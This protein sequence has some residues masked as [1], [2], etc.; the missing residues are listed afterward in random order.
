MAPLSGRTYLAAYY[1]WDEVGGQEVKEQMMLNVGALDKYPMISTSTLQETCPEG[2]WENPEVVAVLAQS[3]GTDNLGDTLGAASLRDTAMDL[4]LQSLIKPSNDGLAL[5]S[6]LEFLPD[7]VP[8]LKRKVYDAASSLELTPNLV[9]SLVKALGDDADIDLSPFTN[10]SASDLSIVVGALH[11][12]SALALTYPIDLSLPRA[13]SKPYSAQVLSVKGCICWGTRKVQYT[14]LVLSSEGMSI[15]TRT[16][17]AG[18][19]LMREITA[20]SNLKTLKSSTFH[21]VTICPRWFGSVSQKILLSKL[22]L[23]ITMA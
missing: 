11:D 18:H 9:V 7:F 12:C 3:S 1:D 14:I 23:L 15:S 22:G 17:S 8:K 13:T 16:C 4:L 6:N 5:L 21:A 2:E 20:S 10:F 19:L